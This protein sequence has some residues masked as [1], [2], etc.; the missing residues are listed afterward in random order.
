MHAYYEAH[1]YTHQ[2]GQV[3]TPGA[4]WDLPNTM[5]LVEPQQQQQQQQ[6]QVGFF[7]QQGPNQYDNAEFDQ[8]QR[9]RQE[10]WINN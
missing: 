5:E 1:Y 2:D 9:Q 4:R 3:P 8:Y 10:S 6:D 7:A